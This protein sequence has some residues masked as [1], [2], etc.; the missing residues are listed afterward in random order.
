MFLNFILAHR[1]STRLMEYQVNLIRKF[2]KANEGTTIKI[3][4]FVDGDNK[5]LENMRYTWNSLN[6]EPIE[7]PNV[8]DDINRSSASPSVSFGL[9]ANYVY[10]KYIKNNDNDIF[11][12]IENDVFPFKEINIEEYVKNYEMCGEIRF[13]PATLPER[14]THFWL[15]FLVFNKK[16]MKNSEIFGCRCLES[17]PGIVTDKTY[18]VDCGAET[19]YWIQKDKEERKIKQIKTVGSGG[20]DYDPFVS[21]KCIVYNIKTDEDIEKLPEIFRKKYQINFGVLVYE[22]FLIHL[23]RLGKQTAKRK[24]KWWDSCYQRLMSI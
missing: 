18:W 10:E 16:L 7:I 19:F 24:M 1:N 21:D 4:G 8:I 6:V 14:F 12:L 17:M 5:F 20:D 9:A 13:N 22:D 2:F 3:Y 23:E 15:G 11:I